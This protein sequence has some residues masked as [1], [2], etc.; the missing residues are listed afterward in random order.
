MEEILTYPCERIQSRSDPW[1]RD[2]AAPVQ[3]GATKR[4]A[5]D[6]VSVGQVYNRNGCPD[7]G[8]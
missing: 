1:A 6:E 5:G 2:E 3:G 7:F 8:G 4:A